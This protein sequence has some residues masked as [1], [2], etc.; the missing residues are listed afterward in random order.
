MTEPLVSIIMN[1]YNASAFVAGAIQSVLDQ[2]YE[3]WEIIFWDNCS[4]DATPDIVQKFQDPRIRYF[5]AKSFTPLGLARNHAIELAQGEFI[6]FLDCDD[7]WF[8]DKLKLQIPLFQDEKIGLVYSDTIFFNDLGHERPLYGGHLPCKG[9]CFRHLLGDYFLSM[10]TVVIRKKAL[11]QET[12]YFDPRFNM[13]EEAD[14][15]RRI[16]YRWNIAGIQKPLA[17]WRVHA[18]SWTFKFPHLLREETELMIKDYQ[19]RILDFD[20]TYAVEL[21]RL[22]EGISVWEARNEWING[23]K[24]PLVYCFFKSKKF[25]RKILALLIIIWPAS[26]AVQAIRLRG[27]ILPASFFSKEKIK[28]SAG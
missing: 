12:L 9:G 25:L 23:N 2:T 1:G 26:K 17:K 10:E 8:A 7:V 15:F 4:E 16:A 3:N 21:A 27:N 5:R 6:A 14:L 11:E 22:R 19:G 13:I 20:T 18:S 28:R 24:W